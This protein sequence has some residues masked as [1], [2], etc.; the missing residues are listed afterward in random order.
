MKRSAVG[1]LL[2]LISHVPCIVRTLWPKGAEQL[3]S[4]TL[5]QQKTDIPEPSAASPL[6]H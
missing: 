4:E 1:G 2:A 6:S 3:C 5:E